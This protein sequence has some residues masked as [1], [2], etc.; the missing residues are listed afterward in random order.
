[1]V[2]R[3]RATAETLRENAKL[4][5]ASSLEVVQADSM[6]YL[7][8]TTELFDVAFVDPP[9]ASGLA[10]SALRVLPA[11]LKPGGRAYVESAQPLGLGAPWM[12]LREDRAGAVRYALYELAP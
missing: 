2:E 12:L 6:R 1:M 5:G 4:L 11:R 3:D 7:S 10:A 9:Y 8:M